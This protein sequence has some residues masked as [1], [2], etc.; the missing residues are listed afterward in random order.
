MLPRQSSP[1]ELAV[2]NALVLT[3]QADGPASEYEVEI[4]IGIVTDSTKRK[5]VKQRDEYG[6]LVG[7]NLQFTSAV[8]PLVFMATFQVLYARA[9]I[10]TESVID[11]HSRYAGTVNVR[12]EQSST[13][14]IVWRKKTRY[15]QPVDIGG[16]SWCDVRVATSREERVEVPNIV[17]TARFAS[18]HVSRSRAIAKT[19]MAFPEH[20]RRRTRRSMLFKETPAWRLDFTRVEHIGLIYGNGGLCMEHMPKTTSITHEIELE[21]IGNDKTDLVNAAL[22]GSKLANAICWALGT[23]MDDIREKLHNDRIQHEMN[24]IE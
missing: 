10:V 1:L 5:R 6:H 3:R 7:S 11:T 17:R 8:S 9:V 12:E 18:K 2:Y 19:R 13:G 16:A 23:T 4:R 15:G 14:A 22:D 21:F 20:S 24:S